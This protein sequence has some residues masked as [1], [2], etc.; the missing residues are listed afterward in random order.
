[1]RGDLAAVERVV[2]DLHEIRPKK[3]FLNLLQRQSLP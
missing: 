1:L 2:L 3:P